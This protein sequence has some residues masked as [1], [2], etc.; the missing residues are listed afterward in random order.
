[1]ARGV[2]RPEAGAGGKDQTQDKL[3]NIFWTKTEQHVVELAKQVE[4]QDRM[5]EK[6]RIGEHRKY[7]KAPR[8]QK[9]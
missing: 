1:M 5:L 7:P 4:K 6:F 2:E 9:F 3:L 8:R